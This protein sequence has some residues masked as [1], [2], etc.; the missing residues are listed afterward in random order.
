MSQP[1]QSEVRQKTH[2]WPVASPGRKGKPNRFRTSFRAEIEKVYHLCG[3]NEGLY[4]WALSNPKEFY[5]LVLKVM[6]TFELKQESE[7]DGIKVIVY[8]EQGKAGTTE[9]QVASDKP[10]ETIPVIETT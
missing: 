7:H 8:G 5:P 1:V 10:L 4:Q 2:Y 9:V 3:G 6:A